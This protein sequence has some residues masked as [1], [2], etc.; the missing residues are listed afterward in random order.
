MRLLTKQ[1][2]ENIQAI[3]F[4]A[5]HHQF[6]TEDEFVWAWTNFVKMNSFQTFDH[7]HEDLVLAVDFNMYGTRMATASSDHTIKVWDKKNDEWFVT[8][9]WRAHDAEVVD[10]KW[11][12]PHMGQVLGSIGEDGRFKLWEEDVV[13]APNSGRRFKMITSMKSETKVPFMS[14]DIKNVS[15][16]ETYIALITRDGYLTVHEP[17]DHDNLAE[18]QILHQE[19]VCPRPSRQDETGF[20]VHFHHDGLPCW[21]ALEAG[22]DRKS[23]GLAVAAMDVVK[24]L[25]TDKER[26]FYVAAELPGAR[27]IIRDVAWAKGSMRGYDVVATGCKDG[28]IRIYELYTPQAASE[29]ENPAV[30]KIVET[31][32]S[33]R[34]RGGSVARS[35]IGVGLAGPSSTAGAGV[36]SQDDENELPGRVKQVVKKVAELTEHHGAVWR[37]SWSHQGNMLISTGDDGALRTWKK[38]L[39]GDWLEASEVN[40]V[41]ANTDDNGNIDDEEDPDE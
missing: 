10:V 1:R 2:E 39:D 7:G 8:D 15:L 9:Q 35:G 32:S 18:W 38:S 26:R 12:G 27:N 14:L 34:G 31:P 17:V 29:T 36:E 19:Y 24:I 33:P 3:D 20:R 6:A 22:L 40:L 13:E 41:T 5:D 16:V 30:P 23:L 21:P 25:R 4:A 37:L 28:A 11:N